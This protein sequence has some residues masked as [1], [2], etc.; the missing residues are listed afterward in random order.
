[1]AFPSSSKVIFGVMNEPHEVD[2]TAW[3]TTVQAVV[4]AI[5]GAG[6]TTQISKSSLGLFLSPRDL[7]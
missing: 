4:A 7:N 5:R 3:A 1:M 2:I 6:A